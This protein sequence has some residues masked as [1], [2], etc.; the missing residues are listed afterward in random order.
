MEQTLQETH[1][2]HT[3][4]EVEALP[5]PFNQQTFC[6]YESI[7]KTID[8]ARVLI[9]DKPAARRKRFV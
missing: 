4:P 2:D 7:E 3:T 8:A 1:T 9:V 6:R 5:F